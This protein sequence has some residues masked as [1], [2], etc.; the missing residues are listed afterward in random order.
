MNLI[1]GSTGFLGRELLARLLKEC[2]KKTCYLLL[3]AEGSQSASERSKT[4]LRSIFGRSCYEQYLDRVRP[5]AGDISLPE[6]GLS[7]SSFR[8]LSAEIDTVY[9]SAASTDLASELL[10]AREVNVGG[11][12]RVLEFSEIAAARH[13]NFRLH[14][15]STAYVAGDTEKIVRADQLNLNTNF[16]NAYEQSKAEAEQLVRG[17]SDQG[18]VSIYRP[19]VIVGDSVTGK[20]TAF[21]VIYIPLRL[22]INGLLTSLPAKPHAPFDVVPINYVADAIVRLSQIPEASGSCFHLSAGV[23]RE[24]N[25]HEIIEILI[26]TFQKCRKKPLNVPN[27]IPQ[28]ILHRAF[29]SFTAA[30][31]GLLQLEKRVS[32]HIPVFRQTLPFIPYM[33]SNPQFDTSTTEHALSPY[34][35][36]P[37]LFRNYA[38]R[39]FAYCFETNWGKILPESA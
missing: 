14:H 20:T 28:E 29:N 16:R 5:L 18:K 12:K 35:P 7:R 2:P 19:S 8:K 27:F 10:T 36:P 38:E 25:P 23:G 21:K 33:L 3:R 39:I 6:F 11:T 1:T 22:V 31:E 17:F 15:M 32:K 26:Q 4:L 34:M 30:A 24:S 9:H 13:S 37:P